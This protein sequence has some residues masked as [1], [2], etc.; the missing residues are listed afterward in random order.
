MLIL[1]PTE[2]VH[3]EFWS[4]TTASGQ[5]YKKVTNSSLEA[6][7]KVVPELRLPPFT[8]SMWIKVI[9]NLIISFDDIYPKKQTRFY[10][11]ES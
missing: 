7:R 10:K 8:P 11:S 5:V 6:G 2:Q 4:T 1:Q 3:H 9:G